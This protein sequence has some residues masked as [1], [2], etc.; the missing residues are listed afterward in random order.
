ME[1][2]TGSTEELR[3]VFAEAA[4]SG[5]YTEVTAEYREFGEM[6]VKWIRCGKTIN[7]FVSDYLS[8]AP[9]NVLESMA[10]TIVS[11]ICA[12]GDADY[13]PELIEW[14]T[15]DEF[16]R[17]KQGIYLSRRPTVIPA[18]EFEYK[19][20]RESCR[21]IADAGLVREDDGMCVCWDTDVKYG[22]AGRYSVLMKVAG[23]AKGLDTD[24]ISDEAFDLA[25]YSVIL[26]IAMGFSPASPERAA[27]YEK[28][29]DLFPQREILEEELKRAGYHL[30]CPPGA[31]TPFHSTAVTPISG[32]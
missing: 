31:N 13:S 6:K 23:I 9:R 21:R 32:H 26:H 15:S 17:K 20:P 12:C 30:R 2:T 11:K 19:D 22:Y 28:R 4:D 18:P 24:E 10:R 8:D 5:G 27:E 25:V 14:L 7:F 3:E 16:P 29:L 1:K